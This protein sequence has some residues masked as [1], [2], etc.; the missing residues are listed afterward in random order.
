MDIYTYIHTYML[1]FHVD[2]M[3]HGQTMVYGLL[4]STPVHTGN[5][6]NG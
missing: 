6:Y 5:P 3:C 1:W 2:S 4:Q